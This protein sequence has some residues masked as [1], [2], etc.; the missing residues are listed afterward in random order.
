MSDW[1][2]LDSVG[3]ADFLARRLAGG[4]PGRLV[5]RTMA[6]QLAYG[7]HGGPIPHAAR[8]AAVLLVLDRMAGEWSIPAILRPTTMKAHAGQVSLPGGLIEPGETAPQAALREFTEELGTATDGIQILGSLSPVFVFISNFE[9]T[10]LLA[11]SHRLLAFQPNP[12]EVEAVVYLPL[13]QLMDPGCRGSHLIQ[14][15]MLVFRA[16][17]FAI[18]SQQIW[19]ATS[20]VLAEFGALVAGNSRR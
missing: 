15:K 19:G 2:A 9:V 5:Q 10:P 1:E 16:P 6:P 12:D 13:R 7:R 14:R 17:H 20:L 11:V 3:M 4:L 8:R 18:A